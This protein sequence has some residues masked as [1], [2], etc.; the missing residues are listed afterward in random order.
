MTTADPPSLL[1]HAGG[2]S[3]GT[4]EVLAVNIDTPLPDAV[5]RAMARPRQ[6]RFTPLVCTDNA[7]RFL[8][9]LPIERLMSHL[10]EPSSVA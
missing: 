2:G 5:T 7:G 6:I 9:I 3:W 8:G 4:T 10:A 1:E